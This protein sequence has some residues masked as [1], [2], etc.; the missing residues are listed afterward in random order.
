MPI[1]RQTDAAGEN[2]SHHSTKYRI[3]EALGDLID[4]CIDA[5]AKVIQ[6]FIYDQDYTAAGSPKVQGVNEKNYPN[7]LKNLY[8]KQLYLTVLDDGNGMNSEEM[9]D[10][11]IYGHRRDYEDYE[12]GHFGVGLKNSTMSQAYEA[13]IISKQ[14]SEINTVRISSVHI[15]STGE[16]QLLV[17]DDLQNIYPWMSNTDG[18]KMARRELSLQKSGTAVLLEGMHKIEREIGKEV[19][20]DDY[21]DEIISRLKSQIG[22]TFH[23][24][25]TGKAKIKR[26]DGTFKQIDR[27]K[28]LINGAPIHPLDPFFSD[29]T[30]SA[31][32]HWTLKRK[33]FTK[34]LVDGEEVQLDASAY[35]I[36]KQTEI[37]TNS[38]AKILENKLLKVRPKISRGELQGIYLFR[39]QRLIDFASKDPWKTLGKSHT[40]TVVGRWEIHLPPHEPHQLGDLDFTLDKTKTDT[41]FGETTKE[42]LIDYWSSST[43]S[44]H[45]LD[46]S[47]VGTKKRMEFRTAESSFKTNGIKM[48]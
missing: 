7:G 13:T 18:Y 46:F 10:A 34:T 31:T 17:E 4:N 35:I 40:S 43:F 19:D 1:R 42:S 36:P 48:Q 24:Y 2:N 47:A 45:P 23:R 29:F 39:H 26:T 21:I 11:L 33:L 37:N 28:I 41:S 6:I 8:D 3:E 30:D 38:K 22:L 27:I 25:L 9:N 12:L 32:N 20:R 44:W 16:D 5:E 15:Q 14:N